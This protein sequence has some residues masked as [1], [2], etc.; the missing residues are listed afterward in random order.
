MKSRV[1]KRRQNCS[2]KSTCDFFNKKI[3]G[4]NIVSVLTT[5]ENI[6]PDVLYSCYY[7][8]LMHYFTVNR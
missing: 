8:F 4:D 1:E 6:L 3:N 2:F 7:P 5:I